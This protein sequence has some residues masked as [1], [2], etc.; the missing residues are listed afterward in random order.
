MQVIVDLVV[1]LGRGT[2]NDDPTGV[3]LNLPSLT[4]ERQQLKTSRKYS[5]LCSTILLRHICRTVVSM[6]ALCLLH[7]LSA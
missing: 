2:D 7:W 4:R 3:R 6:S 1:L 5:A